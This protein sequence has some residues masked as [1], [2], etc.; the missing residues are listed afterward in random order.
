[1]WNLGQQLTR[2]ACFIGIH[3]WVKLRNPDGDPYYECARCGKYTEDPND[4]YRGTPGGLG[5]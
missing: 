2:L 4:P 1:V 3:R 5:I